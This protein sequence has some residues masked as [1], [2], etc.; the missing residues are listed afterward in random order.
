MRRW[1]AQKPKSVELLRV[2]V[3]FGR[4]GP[5]GLSARAY[6]VAEELNVQEQF[7][8][9]I[10]RKIHIEKKTPR[11]TNDIGKIFLTLG[12]NERAFKKA[13][14]SFSVDSKLRKAEFL[15]KKYKVSGVPYFLINKK[16][17]TGKDSYES[18]QTLFRLWNQL[19]A[20][21]F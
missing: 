21:D 3:S 9:A 17:E 13:N 6:Y 12:I 8:K 16:Y 18:E 1:I 15:T 2:P 7:S 20:K 5:W 10:F 4:T 19:P 11:S 14:S